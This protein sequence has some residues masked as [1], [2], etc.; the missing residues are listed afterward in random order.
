MPQ[1]VVEGGDIDELGDRSMFDN[2]WK[3]VL[4]EQLGAIG[5]SLCTRDSDADFRSQCF[6]VKTGTSEKAQYRWSL[7]LALF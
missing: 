1:L 7:I 2:W 4:H 6:F 5:A 3:V